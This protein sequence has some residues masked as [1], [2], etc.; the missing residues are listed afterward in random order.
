MIT[1]TFTEKGRNLSLR[2]EGH[3]GYAEPGKDIICASASILAITLASIIDSF[4]DVESAINLESGDATIECECE[5]NE[6]FVKV[7]NAYHYTQI[8]YALLAQK[9]PQYVRLMP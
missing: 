9:Y 1:V 3:A 5:D 6:T 8:G 2:V 4:D 7:A